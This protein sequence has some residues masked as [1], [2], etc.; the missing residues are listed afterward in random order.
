MEQSQEYFSGVIGDPREDERVKNGWSIDEILP[1]SAPV[2]WK[3]KKI[4]ELSDYPIW[5]QYRTSACVAFAKAKQVSIAIF[6]LTGVW[7]DFSPAS[8]YQ[9]RAN[10]PGLG[11]NIADA[12]DIVNNIGVT[13]EALMKSQNLTEEEIHAV[14]RTRVA[15]LFAKAIA[16][17][18]VSYVY[19]P[20]TID[21]IAQTIES[22]KAV[23]LLIF[24][25]PDE[26][27]DTPKIKYPNLTYAQAEI[28]HEVDATDYY[29]HDIYNKVLW[30]DDSWGVGHGQGGHRNFTEEF[31]SKR[32][33][34]AD[35]ID[36]FSFDGAPKT[37][38]KFE[39]NLKL[40]D[41]N[42]EVVKLQDMLKYEKVF[43]SNQ[44]STGLYG[45]ITAGA[46]LKWQ[47]ANKVA[48]EAE[49]VSLKGE[50]FG[51]ASRAVANAKFIS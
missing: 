37:T 39:T 40:G 2:N 38:F 32:V 23:S 25:M 43:P 22:G 6:K 42:Q 20:A 34:L 45:P 12:N 17:A 7:I 28:R 10:K 51:P 41:N 47:L 36:V 9:L 31:I 8:I 3:K 44:P 15:D 48:P 21:R 18:V 29:I 16:E 49:L 1:A 46:V 4:S 13:L 11:M 33:I 14:K 5:N 19:V 26:Y 24:A 35:A 30:I 50:H 27:T